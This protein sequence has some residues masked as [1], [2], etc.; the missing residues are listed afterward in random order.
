VRRI[1]PFFMTSL[2]PLPLCACQP[3]CLTEREREGGRRETEGRRGE[4]EGVRDGE[5]EE[6]MGIGGPRVHAAAKLVLDVEQCKD[7][8]RLRSS[9]KAS[10]HTPLRVRVRPG[11]RAHACVCV[12]VCV[13]GGGGAGKMARKQ[14][15]EGTVK[16]LN[17]RWL[18]LQL[19][20]SS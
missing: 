8:V 20:G 6:R 18:C 9:G 19:G 3:V 2:A 13:W 7:H 12:C 1:R 11:A 15:V 5:S 10:S 14:A 16:V 17:L 4:R